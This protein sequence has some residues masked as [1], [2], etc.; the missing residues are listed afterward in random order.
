M[1]SYKNCFNNFD[2][3]CF[4]TAVCQ[5]GISL[6][7][8][9]LLCVAFTEIKS[10][11]NPPT[12]EKEKFVANFQN[13]FILASALSFLILLLLSFV[14]GSGIIY[15]SYKIL[16]GW[17]SAASIFSVCSVVAHVGSGIYLTVER[18]YAVGISSIVVSICVLV[19]MGHSILIIYCLGKDYLRSQIREGQQ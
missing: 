8:F 5:F 2:K 1:Q 15:K 19:F 9:I 7:A 12:T 4:I 14:L 13:Y 6:L 3:A 10:P 18:A 16:F 17:M 11:E